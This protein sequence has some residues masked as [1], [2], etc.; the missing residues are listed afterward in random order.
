M[1]TLRTRRGCSGLCR[2]SECKIPQTH[3]KRIGLS[4]QFYFLQKYENDWN[5]VL[6]QQAEMHT[7]AF[8][9]W[10]AQYPSSPPSIL[11]AHDE[12]YL[13]GAVARDNPSFALSN[14][15]GSNPR[16]QSGST[17]FPM[18]SPYTE[19]QAD[20]QFLQLPDLSHAARLLAP[21][22]PGATQ[23]GSSVPPCQSWPSS[24]PPSDHLKLTQAR[25]SAR[26]PASR[27]PR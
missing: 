26:T 23:L 15:E 27:S 16:G 10:S 5:A 13:Y 8:Q 6:H 22:S 21:N 4:I 25:L 24:D 14:G 9:G 7:I 12:P 17:F 3:S 20:L 19:L 2:S 11:V 18:I 1:Q